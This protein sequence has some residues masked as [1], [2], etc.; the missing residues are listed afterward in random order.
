M[1]HPQTSHPASQGYGPRFF[2]SVVNQ[3]I[4]RPPINTLRL[5]EKATKIREH[6]V[7]EEND[8]QD[9]GSSKNSK[10]N[11]PEMSADHGEPS[12]RRHVLQKAQSVLRLLR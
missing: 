6:A 4:D 12:K 10:E 3:K 1:N 9:T 2:D 7:G 5:I 11:H 8:G